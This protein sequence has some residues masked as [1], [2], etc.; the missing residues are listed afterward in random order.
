METFIYDVGFGV[1]RDITGAVRSFI[2]V[3]I[4]MMKQI[5]SCLSKRYPSFLKRLRDDL[6]QCH[7]LTQYISPLQH[8]SRT[9]DS[10][11]FFEITADEVK[12]AILAFR[13]KKS[14]LDEIPS[15][16]FKFVADT[17]SSHLA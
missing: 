5:N 3:Q 14:I 11:V 8:I 16:A 12:R 7:Y 17:I 13:Y 15:Y 1:L 4:N 9:L 2:L 10:F 6:I